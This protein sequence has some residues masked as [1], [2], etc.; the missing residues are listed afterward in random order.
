MDPALLDVLN[1]IRETLN[2][3]EGKALPPRVQIA[4]QLLASPKELRREVK[5]RDAWYSYPCTTNGERIEAALAIADALLA[6]HAETAKGE[7]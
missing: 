3:L 2:E 4:A 7:G 1:E 6:A 5:E